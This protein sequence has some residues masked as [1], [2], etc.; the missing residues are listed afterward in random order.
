[1]TVLA[2]NIDFVILILGGHRRGRHLRVQESPQIRHVQ[3]RDLTSRASVVPGA[4][5]VLEAGTM[6]QVPAVGNVTGN[7]TRV[8]VLQANWTICV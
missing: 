5:Q 4:Q 7:A 6:Q 8:Y 1:M 2:Q 3:Q